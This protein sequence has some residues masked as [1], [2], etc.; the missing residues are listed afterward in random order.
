MRRSLLGLLATFLFAFGVAA[1]PLRIVTWQADDFPAPP[2]GATQND[3]DVKRLK[4][5]GAALK[6]FDASVIVLEGMPDRNSC[7]RLTGYLK[8][9]NFQVIQFN[10]FRGASNV[11]IARS[12]AVLGRKAA[13]SARSV[14]WKSSGQ[15]D[16]GGGFHFS[17]LA[18]G[19]NTVC[20]YVAQFVDLPGARTNTRIAQLNAQKRELATQYLLHHSK[21]LE[22]SLNNPNMA[23][24]ALGNL[25]DGLALWPGDGS[26]H[27]LEQA[28]YAGNPLAPASEPAANPYPQLFA[29]NAAFS[30]KPQSA[31]PKGFGTG[32]IVYELIAKPVPP[33]APL[34]AV[35]PGLSTSASD[36]LGAHKASGAGSSAVD[37]RF[38]WLAAPVVVAV[39]IFLVLLLPY[40]ILQGKRAVATASIGLNNSNAN[41]NALVP[42]RPAN[43]ALVVDFAKPD[44]EAPTLDAGAGPAGETREPSDPGWQE[45]ARKAEERAHQATAVVREGLMPQFVR[46]MREKVLQRLSSQR[47]H[48]I[49]SHVAGTMQVL[50][51]E[52]RLEKIQSQFHTRL[53]ARE[54]RVTDLEKEL[55]AKDGFIRELLK[56][57]TKPDDRVSSQ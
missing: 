57:Q 24:L 15:I 9:G 55:A 50:E 34:V 10:T 8:P 43:N 51:L 44:D 31:A 47:A 41:S 1:Q 4:Q 28:G 2:N 25:A 6:A 46:L 27:V 13:T 17:T 16:G 18:M 30:G 40:R 45:R 29:R 42:A 35:S 22:G 5:V 11:P 39:L 20:L 38:L 21:W 26:V 14:E 36:P 7:Q 52:E 32:P 37:E 56:A 19:T 3:P 54:Q 12:V 33:P 23:F 48:L 53:S 49:D